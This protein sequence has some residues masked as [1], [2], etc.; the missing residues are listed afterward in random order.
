M[1]GQGKSPFWIIAA[2]AAFLTA[3]SSGSDT[4]AIADVTEVRLG[5]TLVVENTA[6]VLADTASLQPVLTIGQID[7][8]PEYAFSQVTAIAVDDAGAVYVAQLKDGVRKYSRSGTYLQRIMGYGE[9]PSET[10]YANHMVVMAD[11]RLV[12]RSDGPKKLSIFDTS[13][14]LMETRSFGGTRLPYGQHALQV[15]TAGNL[16]VGINPSYPQD[17]SPMPW[18]RA[19]TARWDGID[20]P[21][22]TLLAPV[23]H[24]DRCPTRGTNYFRAGVFDDRRGAYFPKVQWAISPL[25]YLIVGCN[26]TYEFDL[27]HS[28]STVTRVRRT[29]WPVV[30]VSAEERRAAVEWWTIGIRRFPGPESWTYTGPDVPDHKPAYKK[31][32]IVE[33][34]RIWVWT[35]KAS[36]PRPTSPEAPRNY[37]DEV[38]ETDPSGGYFDVFE[39]DGRWLGTVRVPPE[40]K[41]GHWPSSPEPVIRGDTIWAATTDSLEIEYVT[42]YELQWPRK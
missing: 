36:E 15:D 41:Y 20:E 22:D 26:A 33:D 3:C 23:R 10:E 4:E 19:I 8:P 13:G 14:E 6:P 42:R 29:G 32:L 9:G 17:G 35:V 38:W 39:R 24:L 37:P 1:N 12:V 28:D 5:D 2:T 34:G 25:G 27:L 11:G 7:G 18:P 30:P 31:F 16:Y 21:T 40:F